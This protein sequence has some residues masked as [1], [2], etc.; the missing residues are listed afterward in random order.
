V[1]S[2][3]FAAV[4]LVMTSIGQSQTLTTSQARSHDGDKA[5]VCGIVGN[6]HV[7]MGSRGKPTFI[8]LDSAFP[9]Q[10]FAILVWEEDR[11]K[12]GALPRTGE[13]VCATGSI[14]YYHGVPRIIVRNSTQ[15]NR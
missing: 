2:T 1:K 4:L 3:G 11:Q 15:F 7:A 13:H 12:V 14:N 8:D 6:E 10:V 9:N 5:T